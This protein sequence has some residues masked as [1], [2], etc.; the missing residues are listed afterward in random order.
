MITPDF[1]LPFPPLLLHAQF[2]EAL[3]EKIK[4][5]L[6]STYP[7]DLMETIVR[8]IDEELLN[9]TKNSRSKIKQSAGK[10]AHPVYLA[11]V[12]VWYST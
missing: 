3:E 1:R 9:I 7:N 11:M 4:P 12:Q 2:V 5:R 6:R 10:N 8:D